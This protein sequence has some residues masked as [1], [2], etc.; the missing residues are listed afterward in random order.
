MSRIFV[1]LL[2]YRKEG[3]DCRINKTGGKRNSEHIRGGQA[4]MRHGGGE[5]LLAW[6]NIPLNC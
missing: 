3:T 1:E 4:T 5:Y 6:E 2:G